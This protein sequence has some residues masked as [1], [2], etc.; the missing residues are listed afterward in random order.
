MHCCKSVSLEMN[1]F[2]L[3]GIVETGLFLNIASRVY[4]GNADGSVNIVDKPAG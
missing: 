2:F 4:Y 1:I 3:S